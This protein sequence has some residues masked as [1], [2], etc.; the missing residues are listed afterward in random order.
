MFLEAAILPWRHPGHYLSCLVWSQS[1]F[2]LMFIGGR[3]QVVLGANVRAG[4]EQVLGGSTFSCVLCSTSVAF[5]IWTHYSDFPLSHHVWDWTLT[6]LKQDVSILMNLLDFMI[7]E[8]TCLCYKILSPCVR[9]LPNR[10][11]K[12]RQNHFLSKYEGLCRKQPFRVA[13]FQFCGPPKVT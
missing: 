5:L 3:A 4:F 9:V 11:E 2:H 10:I 8:R 13:Q 7:L 6:N 1:L 12:A